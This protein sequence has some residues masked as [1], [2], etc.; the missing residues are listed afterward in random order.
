MTP[1]RAAALALLLGAI[2]QPMPAQILS[3]R[4]AMA[5]PSRPAD[6]RIAYGPGAEQFGD[7]RLPS[8]PGRHPVVALVHGGC[9]LAAY[10]LDYLGAIADALAEA[11]IATW[12][13]EFRRVGSPGGGWPGTMR[14]VGV[15][16]DYLRVLATSHPLDLG[17]VALSGHSAGG[18]LVLWAAARGKQPPSSPLHSADPL[19]V[20]GVVALAPI[21]DLAASVTAEYPL[22][23]GSAAQLMGGSPVEV[24]DRY[25]L[26]SPSELLPLGVPYVI[27]NGAE[28]PIVPVAH[29]TA[30]AERARRAG[31]Q[32]RLEIVP[33]SGHFEPVAPGTTAFAVTLAAI[34]ELLGGKD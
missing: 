25:A 21:A 20:R 5:I 27:V 23:N 22:C 2:P 7:L 8:G 24:A 14:D 16:I 3:T 26:A 6:H 32:V 13:I 33:A 18:H 28:D 4:E 9:W 12:S 19:P 34:R 15:A 10:G 29:V 11:G 30:F 1:R 31:D 17:R